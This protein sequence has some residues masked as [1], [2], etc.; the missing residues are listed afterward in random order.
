MLVIA[1]ALLAAHPFLARPG[2]PRATDVE[3]HV[4]RAAELGHALRGGA[5]YVRW[6]PDLWYGYGYPI[7]NYYAP[8]TYYL[9]NAFALLPGLDIVVGAKAILILGLLLAAAGAFLLGRDLFGPRAGLVAAAAYTFSPYI[10]FVNP[11]M[12][13]DLPEC[14]ALALFP[15]LMRAG[16]SSFKFTCTA[17]RRECQVSGL[18]PRIAACAVLW[19]ALILTHNLMALILSVIFVAWQ[20]YYVL[21][22]TFHVSSEAQKLPAKTA[23]LVPVTGLIV[24]AAGLSAFFWLPFVAERGAVHLTVIGEGHFDF[25]NHFVA[26]RSLFAPSRPLD[27]GATAPKFQYNLG[28]VHWLLALPAIP[29]AILYRRRPQGQ[30]LAFFAACS[31]WLVFLMLSPSAFV[32]E[33][34]PLM[35]YIQFPWRLLGPAA[36]TLAMCVGGT[37][38]G[39]EATLQAW[40]KRLP[41]LPV[42]VPAMAGLLAAVCL[43]FLLFSALPAMYPPLW[44][45]DFGPTTPRGILQVELEG[46]YLG[47]TSTGDFVPATVKAHPP[48]NPGLIASYEQGLVDKFDH[49]TLPASAEV[50]VVEHGPRRD[51]FVLSSP[52]AFTARVLTFHFPGWEARIDGESVPI[53]PSSPHGFIEIDVPAGR[54]ELLVSFGTTPPRIAGTLASLLA[55]TAIAF[56]VSGFRF[57][58][59]SFKFQVSSFKSQVSS[60]K[61]EILVI[62]IFALFKFA[63]ADPCDGRY[64]GAAQYNACFRYTSPPGQALSAQHRFDAPV[65]FGYQVYLLG[66]D[67]PASQV[68]AGDKLALTL[69]WKAAAP[70]PTNYQVFVHLV[71]PA[72]SLW[73]QSDKLNPGDFPT[74]RWPLDKFVWDDHQLRVLPGAPPGEYRLSVGLYTLGDGQRVLAW[75]GTGQALGDSFTLPASVQVLPP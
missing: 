44:S 26:W 36:L 62:A 53:R 69:Y 18:T 55:L 8:L 50:R 54:H 14:F 6:A 57:Q 1:L 70:I 43:A 11:H 4:F 58:V 72:T 68:R 47:T 31:A 5:G 20:A 59:S 10:L 27:L 22:F 74:T 51:R 29:L 35:P 73:G 63:V 9:A 32:W 45:P 37:V 7:F 52:Q 24:L 19:A 64:T 46:H 15:W 41:A 3:L 12:R 75:D 13:G 17:R 16:V 67:L 71:E 66:Y 23:Y 42:S 40:A 49:S 21:R 48:A 33:R 28:L 39:A 65:N 2:L 61:F 56:Q 60:L 30:A 38:W 25:H 34:V